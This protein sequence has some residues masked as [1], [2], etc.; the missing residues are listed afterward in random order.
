MLKVLSSPRPCL[1]V[2]P[3]MRTM[4]FD[5]YKGYLAEVRKLQEFLDEICHLCSVSLLFF[6]NHLYFS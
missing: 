5:T 3:K 2:T 4:T 1:K 6:L